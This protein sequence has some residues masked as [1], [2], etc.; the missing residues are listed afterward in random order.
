MPLMSLVTLR[1]TAKWK[2][3]LDQWYQLYH[4]K[5]SIWYVMYDISNPRF[6]LL[7]WYSVTKNMDGIFKKS[8]F[9]YLNNYLKPLCRP[10]GQSARRAQ[11]T[12][13]SM[14]KAS[15][16]GCQLD[17]G[18]CPATTVWLNNLANILAQVFLGRTFLINDICMYVKDTK[19]KI[20]N[21]ETWN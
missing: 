2:S 13:S 21:R 18:A 17:V 14:P 19:C 7:C 16:K 1:P 4:M 9:Y 5:I 12:K 6:L 15:P 8:S 10:Q 11:R 20:L 3:C